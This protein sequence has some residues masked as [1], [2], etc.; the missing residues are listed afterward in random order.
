MEVTYGTLVGMVITVLCFLVMP[1]VLFV[2]A[3]ARGLSRPVWAVIG[4]VPLLNLIGLLLL[5]SKPRLQSG[6]RA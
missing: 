6:G 3:G 4:F 2:M 1:A 5:A